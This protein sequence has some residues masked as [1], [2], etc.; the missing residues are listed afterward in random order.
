MATSSSPAAG[1][2]LWQID[3]L[4]GLM[5]VLM[6]LT[7]LPT[8]LAS[9]AGQPF[10][11]V[12]AAEGFVLL[13]GFMAG[14]V[15]AGRERREGETR[16]RAAF[17]GRVAKIYLCQAALLVFLFSVV[18]LI[19]VLLQE[20]AITGLLKYYLEEP[21]HALVGALLLIYSP[22]LLD[23][24]PL[25]VLFMLLSPMV[26][27]HGLRHGWGG[28]LAVSVALWLGA[29]FK[30][31][32]WLYEALAP[33]AGIR[34]PLVQTGAFDVLAWQFLWILGLW[35]GAE[36]STQAA[37][38]P[39]IFPRW[40][41]GLAMAIAAVGF[42]WRH[43][44]GQVPI[45]H[46]ASL[47]IL[48]DKWQLAPLRMLNLFALLVLAMHCAPWLARHLPR[49]RALE[50]LGAASLPVFCAHLVLALLAL[51]LFGAPVAGRPLWMD[52]AILGVSFALLY[53]VALLSQELDRQAAAGRKAR[54]SGPFKA[55]GG[56]ASPSAALPR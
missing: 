49:V 47:N 50:T 22:P 10:G 42:V 24:L 38:A 36:R 35:M 33:A 30:L 34:V 23:I 8:Q 12:S 7:H 41:V 9:P 20:E 45:P 44:I 16:M 11:F 2:R 32:S 55:P 14:L 3:A 21:L 18:A 40:M 53:G 28:I 39:L 6:T 26:L 31:G 5:L 37:R 29:Q 4:R 15:Y 56:P 48:F 25:Y 1:Q 46:D 52:A 43:A 27:L 51:A 19:A 54:G 13:S 17:Y